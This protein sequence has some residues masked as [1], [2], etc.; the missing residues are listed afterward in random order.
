[1]ACLQQCLDHSKWSLNVRCCENKLREDA[2]HCV[3]PKDASCPKEY[4]G[5]EFI[6][7]PQ[8]S[9]HCLTTQTNAICLLEVSIWNIV[10]V[11]LCVF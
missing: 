9:Y 5:K 10:I 3:M 11:N 1:M 4:N 7:P 6:L 2:R 8:H